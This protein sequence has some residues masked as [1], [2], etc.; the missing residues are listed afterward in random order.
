MKEFPRKILI[1]KGY[2]IGWSSWCGNNCVAQYIAEYMPIIEFLESGGK[3]NSEEFDILINELKQKVK[4]QFN[5]NITVDGKDGL[6][7]KEVMA[8]YMIKDHDGSEYIEE[9]EFC[10]MWFY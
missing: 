1:S 6:V 8:P 5:Y 3:K 7:V 4:N 2:G 9:Q 10:D